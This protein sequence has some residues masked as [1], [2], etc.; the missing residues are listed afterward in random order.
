MT[1][2]KFKCFELVVGVAGV[3][4][5]YTKLAIKL[6]INSSYKGANTKEQKQIFASFCS[7]SYCTLSFR[8]YNVA[9]CSIVYFT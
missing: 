6:K 7:Y 4:K 8:I 3:G 9:E 5:H 2:T 1:S